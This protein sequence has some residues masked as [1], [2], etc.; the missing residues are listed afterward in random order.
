MWTR[1]VPLVLLLLLP[2]CGSAGSP[3]SS[4]ESAAPRGTFDY[5]YPDHADSER[6]Q[7]SVPTDGTGEWKLSHLA[8]HGVF[9]TL[10]QVVAVAPDDLWAFGR[11]GTGKD[12]GP[13]ALRGDSR[14]WT[15]DPLPEQARGA[16]LDAA[17]SGPDNVWLIAGST[18]NPTAFRWDGKRWAAQDALPYGTRIE[19]LDA[20]HVWAHSA[21]A[22]QRIWFYDGGGWRPA[23]LPD[24]VALQAFD[25]TS[26]D[27]L[28]A[29]GSFEEDGRTATGVFR[30]DGTRWTRVPL[31]EDILPADDQSA[32]VALD[33]LVAASRDDVWIMGNRVRRPAEESEAEPSSVP[34]AA[35]WD[36]RSWRRVDLPPRWRPYR[37]IADGDGGVRVLAGPNPADL[38]AVAPTTTILSLSASGAWSAAAPTI[39]KGRVSLNALT[40]VGGAVWAVGAA[41]LAQVTMSAAT[42]VAYTWTP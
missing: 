4:G 17:A 39:F 20:T 34:V 32:Y 15:P 24:G 18:R 35:H 42:S 27:D 3:S 28:W 5:L 13:F 33:L 23:A 12:G 38:D 16:V 37:A 10:S 30:S 7:V 6:T 25:A 21:G 19:V 31:G 2:G 11:T 29:L 26:P 8:D 9:D 36:G 40:A 22:V 41:Y 14:R 1:T